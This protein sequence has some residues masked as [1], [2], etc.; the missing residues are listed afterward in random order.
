[1]S[2]EYEPAPLPA[3]P[4]ERRR[5]PGE[6]LDE[7]IDRLWPEARQAIAEVDRTLFQLTLRL[8]PIERLERVT[9]A[10]WELEELRRST[11]E[12]E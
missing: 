7:Y 9:R 11:R 6:S 8:D 3:L 4:E 5:R 12:R 1:M 2:E 10:A